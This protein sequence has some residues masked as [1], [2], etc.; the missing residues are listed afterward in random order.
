M[1]I[2]YFN[3]F[4][5]VVKAKSISKVA[6]ETHISQPALSQQISKFEE[7]IGYKLLDRSNK[8]VKLTKH[9]EIVYKYS[10]SI[11]KTYKSMIEDLEQDEKE[12]KK[13]KIEACWPISDFILPNIIGDIKQKYPTVDIKVFTDSFDNIFYDVSNKVFDLGITY[14]RISNQEV[15]AFQVGYD[16]LVLV[17]NNKYKIP[18]EI[19]VCDLH[20]YPM[21]FIDDKL[22]IKDV[23]LNYLYGSKCEGNVNV[24]FETDSV[25]TV[26][27]YILIRN[28]LSLL[29]YLACKQYIDEGL[30]KVVRL[31]NFDYKFP[32]N[33]ITSKGT[34]NSFI[35]DLIKLVIN[36]VE[37]NKY[38]R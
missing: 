6:N 23:M 17:A 8:G 18:E 15:N 13:L 33:A 10:G 26:I 35:D 20:K 25:N 14:K 34:N 3:Y 32:I 31:K 4:Y 9:G 28:G 2:E 21:I 16:S 37:E 30:L 5:K 1:H 11:I 7:Q 12:N 38:E 22:K 24:D 27:N 36:Y 29:P 19:G